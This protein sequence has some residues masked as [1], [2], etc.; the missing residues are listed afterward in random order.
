MQG[1]RRWITPQ[2]RRTAQV[3]ITLKHYNRRHYLRRPPLNRSNGP[4]ALRIFNWTLRILIQTQGNYIY[5]NDNVSANRK[6]NVSEFQSTCQR[7]GVLFKTNIPS[8]NFGRTE[9][10]LHASNESFHTHDSRT[11]LA[12]DSYL[13]LQWRRLI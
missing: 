12:D 13:R 3:Q 4:I 7:N 6:N 8:P 2:S 11:N 1:M 9:E 5:H 10:M